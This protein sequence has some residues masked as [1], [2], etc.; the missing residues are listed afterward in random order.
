MRSPREAFIEAVIRERQYQ[1][2]RWGTDFDDKNT[3]NDW[4]TYLCR[5][6][7]RG[8]RIDDGPHE[9]LVHLIKVAAIAMAAY[10][11]YAR[12]RGFA[13]RHYDK[14]KGEENGNRE[15]ESQGQHADGQAGSNQTFSS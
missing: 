10:E 3:I 6:A 7:T 15:R 8:T 1:D 5:Y 13:S 11:T 4:T 2:G 9:F 14:P 12:K